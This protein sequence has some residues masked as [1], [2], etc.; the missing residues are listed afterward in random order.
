MRQRFLCGCVLLLFTS[1]MGGPDGAASAI[2]DEVAVQE[3]DLAKLQA[4]LLSDGQG[5][6]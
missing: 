3:V 4:R 1:Q 6:K 2:R 5:L